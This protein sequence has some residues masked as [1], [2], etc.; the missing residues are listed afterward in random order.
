MKKSTKAILCT[1]ILAAILFALY[2]YNITQ[3]EAYIAIVGPMSGRS[4]K[5]G[6]AMLKGA[7]LYQTMLKQSG[8]LKNLKIHLIAFDDQNDPEKARQIALKIAKNDK[9][10]L[11]LGHHDNRSSIEAGAIYHHH[12]IPAL[13]ASAS[14]EKIIDTNEWYFRIIPGN[15]IQSTFVA[16]FIQNE[17]YL[18]NVELLIVDDQRELNIKS[19][20]T[21]ACKKINLPVHTREINLTSDENSLESLVLDFQSND[22]PVAVFLAAND[23]QSAEI[24]TALK[25][26]GANITIV[27]YSNLAMDTFVDQLKQLSFQESAT[28][29]Y[30]SD[31][32]YAATPFLTEM[33]NEQSQLFKESY[34][35]KHEKSPSWLSYTY[36]DA[37]K[38]AVSAIRRSDIFHIKDIHKKRQLIRDYLSNMNTKKNSIQGLTGDIFF[39]QKGSVEA[40]YYL[41]VYHNQQLISSFS[42]FQIIP[43]NTDVNLILDQVLEGSLIKV[44]NRYMRKTEIVYTGIDINEI[45][46]INLTE[47][48]FD[49][50]FYI[51]FRYKKQ[52]AHAADITFENSLQPLEIRNGNHPQVSRVFC[53]EKDNI[54]IQAFRV[55]GTFK[56][57]F[58][59]RAFPFDTHKLSIKFRN[60]K[61]SRD[62]VIYIPDL[63]GMDQDQEIKTEIT[64]RSHALEGWNITNVIYYQNI[65]RNESSL[66]DPEAFKSKNQIVFSRFNTEI[67]IMRKI[68]NYL[69]KNLFLILVLIVISY[70][71]YFIPPDQFSIR[72]SI[73]MSTLLTSAFSHVKLSNSIPVAYLLA[74]EYSFFGVYAIASLS[75]II[76]VLIYKQF[77]KLEHVKQDRQIIH[78]AKKLIKRL[79]VIG[80]IFHPLIVFISSM[81]IPSVYIL[82]PTNFKQVN[83]VSIAFIV[84][85]IIFC[86]FFTRIKDV[87][88]V[89]VKEES[90]FF[91]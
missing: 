78:K 21:K 57:D 26:P 17:L 31:N 41:G 67:H 79:S 8:E 88:S 25:Y 43:Q 75:I 28:P 22:Q 77:K 86:F 10:L 49:A 72:I 61:L 68:V 60:N 84:F 4:Q 18:N 46:D 9:I 64:Q 90:D 34:V 19:S 13:T 2:K 59:F 38:A 40:P 48:T 1:I 35:A 71:T 69:I 80:M 53:K 45:K 42:Q 54:T 63:H 51:W 7:R 5:N 39:N 36:Y 3:H 16:N 55:N 29:G 83:S 14:D 50:N 76:S 70:I 47:R 73:G 6:E 37:M 20:F 12:K 32:I 44:K 87:R 82:N 58:N 11:V 56:G 30:H 52:F 15:D 62:K 66:G 23:K 74:L 65:F 85:M 33:G 27:G 91:E 24:V 81:L 89:P